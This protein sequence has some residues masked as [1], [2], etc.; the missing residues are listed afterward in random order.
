MARG[1]AIVLAAAV[2][3]LF[4]APA[5]FHGSTQAGPRFPAVRERQAPASFSARAARV[6]TLTR[7]TTI[8]ATARGRT[9]PV[10]ARPHRGAPR[11]RLLRA[12]VLDGR[13]LPLVFAVTDHAH[14]GWFRVRLPVRPNGA[15]GWIKRSA[16]STSATNFRVAVQLRRH[17]ILVRRG[18]VTILHARIGVGRSLSPTPTGTYYLTD[19]IRSTD[20]FYGP[21]AFGLSA[22][23]TVYTSFEGGDG[24]VGVHGTNAPAAIGTDIS[25]GCIRVKNAII[26]KLARMLPLGTPVTIIH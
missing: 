10:Y 25:H 13:R 7:Y 15:R 21:Y 12:R 20:P 8:I 26:R 24:Q 22:F 3:G 19:L 9:I 1:V 23:S 4:L 14:K 11:T 17:R 5:V 6:P 16:V 18:R 2:A